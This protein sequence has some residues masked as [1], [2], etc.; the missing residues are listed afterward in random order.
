MILSLAKKSFP[1]YTFTENVGDLPELQAMKLNGQLPDT[2]P[3]GQW[4]MMSGGHRQQWING[5][6]FAFDISC[7]QWLSAE[8]ELERQIFNCSV[9]QPVCRK[10]K[11]FTSEILRSIISP[12]C[13]RKIFNMHNPLIERILQPA[14][15]QL[16]TNTVFAM[17]LF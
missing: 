2:E 1:K 17:D 12:D 9:Y 8:C 4:E 11:G 5:K 10:V 16:E 14:H 6:L 15:N 13:V 7:F 3:N